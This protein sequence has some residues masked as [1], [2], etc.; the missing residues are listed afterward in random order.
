MNKDKNFK[1]FIVSK[2]CLELT[3]PIEESIRERNQ[4]NKNSKD[5]TKDFWIINLEKISSNLIIY[6]FFKNS[7]IY[8]KLSNLY[9]NKKLNKNLNGFILIIS[10]DKI[11]IDWMNLK[12]PN[13]EIF[14]EDFNNIKKLYSVNFENSVGISYTSKLIKNVIKRD[15]IWD[16]SKSLI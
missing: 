12:I 14:E 3:E 5:L 11:F 2:E 10:S 4:S 6:K 9:L 16:N 8:K 13:L 1:Y 7:Q 15:D